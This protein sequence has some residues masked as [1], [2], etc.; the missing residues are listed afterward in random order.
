[1]SCYRYCF[2]SVHLEHTAVDNFTTS[3]PPRDFFSS[4][5]FSQTEVR[6]TYVVKG[7]FDRDDFRMRTCTSIY[8]FNDSE[9]PNSIDMNLYIRMTKEPSKKIKI[10]DIV[11]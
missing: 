11:N 1:M 2:L 4:P 6:V 7:S 3:F 9:F 10:T 8:D 5:T